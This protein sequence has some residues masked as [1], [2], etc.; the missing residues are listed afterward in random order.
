MLVIPAIDIQGGKCVRLTHGDFAT[1]KVYRNNPIDMAILWRKQNAKML[2]I[3]DLDAALTGEPKNF[4]I[5]KSITETV[6]IPVAVGGG[7]RTLP[8]IE[9]YMSAGV[10]RVILGSVAVINPELVSDAVA[11]FGGK[12]IIVGID[13]M[14]GVPKIKGWVESCNISDVELGCR[15]KDLGVERIIYT[16]IS[17][18]GLMQGAGIETTKNFAEQT[19]LKVTA[20]GGVSGYK[21]LLA[22]AELQPFGVDSVIVGKALYEQAFPCQKIW[23]DCEQLVP[24][25]TNFSTAILRGIC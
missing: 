8:D 5:I 7:V 13:A 12:H 18:D 1:V 9:R 17:R 14:H 20:S 11:E 25:D 15:M 4:Q 23:Q 3:V 24:I 2:H 22:L 6:D 19:K 16:D 21:D 10:H